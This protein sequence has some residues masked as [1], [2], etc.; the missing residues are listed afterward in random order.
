MLKHAVSGW[1]GE[2]EAEGGMKHHTTGT[3]ER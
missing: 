3:G 1:V 2:G